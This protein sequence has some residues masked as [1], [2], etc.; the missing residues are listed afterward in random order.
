MTASSPRSNELGLGGPL[1]ALVDPDDQHHRRARYELERQ[2]RAGLHLLVAFPILLEAYTLIL[3]RL[4]LPVAQRWFREIVEGAG[5]VNPGRDDYLEA[6]RR[7]G[8]FGDQDI[9]LFDAV[10]AVV[11][12]AVA[13][14]IWTYDF[15]FDVMR[16][17]VWR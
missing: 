15:R 16:A 9:T 3:R 5:L 17:D 10:L 14:P 13:A 12:E 11:S 7:L 4:G 2:S 6:G 1:Y 8:L